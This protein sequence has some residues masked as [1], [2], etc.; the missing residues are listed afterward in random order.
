MNGTGFFRDSTSA[1]FTANIQAPSLAAYIPAYKIVGISSQAD[2]A[3][4]ETVV[5]EQ[6][7]NFDTLFSLY[8]KEWEYLDS[9]GFANNWNP[10]I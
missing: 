3:E 5:I 7:P 10:D 2:K 4:I 1:Y 9:I 8:R 6:V